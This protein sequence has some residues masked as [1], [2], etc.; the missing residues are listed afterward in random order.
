MNL[1]LHA[2]FPVRLILVL[3]AAMEVSWTPRSL[4]QPD[5]PNTLDTS[6]QHASSDA[7]ERW[8]DLKYGLRIHWGY[9][10]LLEWRRPGQCGQCPTP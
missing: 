5:G 1:T 10:C 4:A 6:Y 7:Y 3:L 2:P 9:Y 8:R